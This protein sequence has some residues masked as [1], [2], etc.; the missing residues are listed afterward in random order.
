MGIEYVGRHLNNQGKAFTMLA[1]SLSART[2]TYNIL[3]DP[4]RFT[5]SFSISAWSTR[6]RIQS[7]DAV[8]IVQPE[9]IYICFNT[10]N[11][12]AISDFIVSLSQQIELEGLAV[13]LE[14][15]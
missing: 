8:M 7:S 9:E 3:C 4:D 1:G 6:D 12:L 13:Q 15:L 11:L 2:D 14:E 5:L 10:G